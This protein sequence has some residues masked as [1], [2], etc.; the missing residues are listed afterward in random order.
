MVIRQVINTIFNS[1]SYVLAQG[2]RSWLIDCGDVDRLLPLVDGQLCGVL[3]THAHFD[4]IYGLNHLL[5]I[6]PAIPV[7]TN[8]QGREG[9]LSDKVNLSRYH[10]EPFVLDN[11]DNIQIVDDNDDINLFEGI[12]AHAVFTPGHCPSCVTWV[13]GDA[14]FT[15]DSYIP[16]I[17]TVTVLPHADESM[18]AHSEKLIRSL[19]GHRTIYPGHPALTACDMTKQQQRYG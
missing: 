6:F 19:Q 14:V 15:G 7:Y 3:L 2:Q 1:C 18:A 17:K 11:P 13:I 10:E 8:Q 9:L 12:D 5:S 4:H 16:G